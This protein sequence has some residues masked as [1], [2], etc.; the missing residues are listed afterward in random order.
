MQTFDFLETRYRSIVV[1][2]VLICLGLLAIVVGNEVSSRNV[3]WFGVNIGSSV[4]N[5]G[6]LFGIIGMMQWAYDTFSR[7]KFYE[8][9]I[10]SVSGTRAIYDLGIVDAKQ[11]SY[12]ADLHD[13]IASSETLILLLRLIPLNPAAQ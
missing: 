12:D 4:S 9:V 2:I 10:A 5:I 7:R 11:R 6:S 13:V 3:V 8:E 1:S